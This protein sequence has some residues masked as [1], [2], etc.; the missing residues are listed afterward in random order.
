[1]FASL[2]LRTRED[3]FSLSRLI[4]EPYDNLIIKA[5]TFFYIVEEYADSFHNIEEGYGEDQISVYQR[6]SVYTRNN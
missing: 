2:L 5:I 1:M 3:T 6:M 4:N